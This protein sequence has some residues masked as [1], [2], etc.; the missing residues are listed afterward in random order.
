MVKHESDAL[1]M[2]ASDE[3][4]G[5]ED[6]NQVILMENSDRILQTSRISDSSISSLQLQRIL[7]EATPLSHL[8]IASK[9]VSFDLP[10]RGN[11][12]VGS[13]KSDTEKNHEELILKV[14]KVMDKLKQ[15]E[16]DLSAEKAIRKKKEKNLMKLAKELKKRNLQKEGDAER[17][18]K[19]G[20]RAIS[21]I[22]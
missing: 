14:A 9:N 5:S 16:M 8:A 4:S 10:L 11:D 12:S 20:R 13:I 19:V 3:S 1:K 18:Q 2:V 22:P 6:G 21:E 15:A 17:L 7:D